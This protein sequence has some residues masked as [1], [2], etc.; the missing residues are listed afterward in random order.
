MRKK[1]EKEMFSFS[2]QI[3]KTLEMFSS[4]KE[5]RDEITKTSGLLWYIFGYELQSKPWLTY[6]ERYL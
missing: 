1:R 3:T 4:I 5:K 6:E 2:N